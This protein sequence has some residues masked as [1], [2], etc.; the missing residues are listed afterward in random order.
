MATTPAQDKMAN[1][2]RFLAVDAVEKANSGHPGL[3]MGAADIATVLFRDVLKFD[4]ADPHWPDRDRFVLSAGHGSMLLYAVLYLTG[5]GGDKGLTIDDLKQFRQVGSKTPGHPEYGHTIGVETTTGPLGQGLGTAVGMAIAERMMAAHFPTVVD[6]RTYVLASDGDLMEGLSHE[7]IAIAGHYKLSKL[8]VFWDNNDISIDGE[9][10]VLNDNVDQ[11]ERFKAAGWNA[12]HVDG[13]DVA[14]I[15]KATRE[16]QKS[17][18]PTL[19]ACRTT[20]GFGA[21]Q[22]E[23]TRHAHGEALGAEEVAGARKNLNWPYPPFVVPDEILAAW[24]DIGARGAADRDEWRRRL[25]E[26]DPVRRDEFERRMNGKLPKGLDAVI[27]AY[28]RQLA[29][30]A[31]EIATRKAG[32]A[33]LNVIAPAV[34][35]LVTGSADLTPSNNTKVAATVEITPDDF[36][37][38]YIHW[39]IREHGMA[40]ACNGLAVHGGI[41]PSGASFLAFTDY[42]RPSLR[43]AA[44]MKIRVVHVFTHDS[45]GLGEDGPT[46][47]PVEHLAS[48]RA[49]PNMY[50]WRPCDSVETVECWQ[51]ALETPHSPSI[52]ALTRQSLPALRRTHVAENLCARGAYEIAP[53]DGAADVSIFASGSEVSLAISAQQILKGKGIAARVVSVP[54]MTVFLAQPDDYRR[55]VIGAAKV[56]AAVEAAVRFGWDAIIGDGPFIGMTGFGES[57][58]YKAVYEFFGITPEAVAK[59]AADRLGA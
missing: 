26:L 15:L 20:I 52:L 37:G 24:R 16:A 56:K 55:S 59:A 35:E 1:A 18:R 44:L 58:P 36:S 41:I 53:A 49:M 7:A 5:T 23:G 11:V 54:C 4:A 33:A 48:L 10:S 46:H 22:K 34:P 57:G 47:Q 28:K 21:P 30:Q 31:P 12:C 25:S 14:A 42:C 32:E 29:E 17:D 43:I 13:R 2:I 19:I 6:H 27:D 38:R 45:I 50:L 8:I 9:V 3:P 40:A 39:G 51:A